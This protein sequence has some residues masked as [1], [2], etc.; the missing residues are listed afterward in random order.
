MSE[1][2]GR[3]QISRP[4]GYKWIDRIETE[5]RA[6]WMA[7]YEDDEYERVD[8]VWLHSAMKLG[9]VFMAPHDRG[10]APAKPPAG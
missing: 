8:G 9:V 10:W 7:G 6:L 5:G 2:C 3:Y 1:L 4:T